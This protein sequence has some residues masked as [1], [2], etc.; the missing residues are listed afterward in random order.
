MACEGVPI[1]ISDSLVQPRRFC[2]GRCRVSD[3]PSLENALGAVE[4]LL[5]PP[6]FPRKP[7]P[8]GPPARQIKVRA[9]EGHQYQHP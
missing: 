9:L 4:M 7:A 8:D 5:V 2:L 3:C 6:S 1:R